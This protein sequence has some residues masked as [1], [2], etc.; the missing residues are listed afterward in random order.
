MS[1]TFGQAPQMP[2][3]VGRHIR[4]SKVKFSNH[5]EYS[6]RIY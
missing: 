1:E 2:G 3:I 6:Y 4:K 5:E